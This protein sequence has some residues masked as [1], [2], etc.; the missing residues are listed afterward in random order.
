MRFCGI[1][2][3]FALAC[4]AGGV[5]GQTAEAR[6][7]PTRGTVLSGE[8]IDLP[9]AL[10]GKVG[11]LVLGF[12]RS[13]GDAV[14]D[15]GKKLY[16]DYNGS[17]AVRYYELSILEPVPGILRGY[18]VKKISESVPDV[19]KSHFLPVLDHEKEWKAAA[20]FKQSDDVYVL[21]VDGTGV[22][23]ARVSGVAS[24]EN[25]AEVKRQV[26]AVR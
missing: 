14:A 17:T 19:A 16:H 7:P 3:G 5:Y 25:F 1:A 23:R 9:E 13:S 4:G 11:V 15:W 21:V 24:D 12:S 2:V 26:D 6:I 8:R 22:V 18:V 10:T 20:G